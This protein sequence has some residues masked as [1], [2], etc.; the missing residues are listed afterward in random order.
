[1][2]VLIFLDYVLIHFNRTYFGTGGKENDLK[3]WSIEELLKN[4]KHKK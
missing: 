4:D 1:M 3:I 2:L